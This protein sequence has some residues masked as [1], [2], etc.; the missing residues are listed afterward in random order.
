MVAQLF[1]DFLRQLSTLSL[2]AAGGTVTLMQTVFAD[3][4]QQAVLVGGVIALFLA[5]LFALQTQQVLV[6]RLAQGTQT[7]KPDGGWL[8]KLKM[9]RTSANEQRLMY[10]AFGLFGAGLALVGLAVVTD[11]LL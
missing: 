4:E 5:A 9:N 2:A 3:S 1:F 7:L 8:A 10:L 11:F 6:E